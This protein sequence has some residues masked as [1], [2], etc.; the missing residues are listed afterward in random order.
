MV[1]NQIVKVLFEPPPLP[2]TPQVTEM[3]F[4]INSLKNKA[5][6]RGGFTLVEVIVVL[7]ILAI[8]AAL[9][10]PSMTGWIDKAKERSVI[11]EC[12]SAVLA[13]QTLYSES[14]ANGQAVSEAEI[15]SLASLP[16]AV[17]DVEIDAAFTV[18][19]LTYTRSPYRVTYCAHPD[20]CAEHTESY[21]IGDG[22]VTS[23]VA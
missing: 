13:A 11:V 6:E 23:W 4:H 14:Y 21:T 10:V 7:V 22:T 12:R 16:G 15:K 9:V 17:S 2:L 8:L 5:R 1:Y 20:T 18:I 19:H 3:I